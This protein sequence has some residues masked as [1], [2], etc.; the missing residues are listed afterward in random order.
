MTVTLE[1]IQEYA[2]RIAER[3]HPV[4]IILY[5]SYA[6]GHP[7]EASDIDLLVIMSYEGHCLDIARTIKRALNLPSYAHLLIKPPEEVQWRYKGGD[8]LIREALNKGKT[9]Y[10]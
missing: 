1:T 9:L 8:P 4:K 7:T 6:Y 10:E 3:F 2:R 5:G